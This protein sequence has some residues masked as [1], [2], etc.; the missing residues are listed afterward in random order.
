MQASLREMT[1]CKDVSQTSASSLWQ[2]NYRTVY[3]VVTNFLFKNED[4]KLNLHQTRD[5]LQLAHFVLK[6]YKFMN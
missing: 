2:L 5:N 1:L 6:G 3:L 4:T